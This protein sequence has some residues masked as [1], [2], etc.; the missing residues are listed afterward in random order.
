MGLSRFELVLILLFWTALA[1]LRSAN[2]VLVS[3]ERDPS[4]VIPEAPIALAFTESAL[5]ALLTPLIF[6]LGSRFRVS[7]EN[8]V[9]RG[10]F[11]V[12][13]GV[14]V[15]TFMEVAT[16]FVRF[17]VLEM[18]SRRGG[19][20]SLTFG[21]THLFWLDDLMVFLAVLAAGFARDFYLRF[22]ARQEEAA[23]LEAQTAR[24]QAQLAESRL[25]ALRTQLNP[26]FLFNPLNAVSALVE[27]D[28]RGVRRMIARLSE[29]LRSTLDQSNEK[30]VPLRRELDFLERY[31]E[32]MQI[33]FQG[34][35]EVDVRVDP[36]VLDALVPNLILQ[37]LV[38]NAIKHG[39]SEVEGVGRITVSAEERDDTLRLR[40]VD[41]GRGPAG[42]PIADGVGVR[43]TRA[44]LAELYG[45]AQS[46][47]LGA[48]EGGG[49]VAEVTLPYHTAGDLRLAGVTA[50]G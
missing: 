12:V 33:R 2:W 28:P 35:L 34:K 45:T 17:V 47:S 14:L 25:A 39:V 6:W 11:F 49:F 26:H 36:A 31:L 23:A 27:R 44:R 4:A 15:S 18:P 22:R 32:I 5:W 21:V 37:P 3:R 10:A 19:P 41:N 43:N 38:E 30:E 48:A 1:L 7:R 46:L 24:L 50:A 29:L 20:P 9:T 13:T 40:V 16:A 8:W 42:G